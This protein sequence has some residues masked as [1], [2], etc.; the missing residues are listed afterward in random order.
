MHP[1]RKSSQSSGCVILWRRVQAVPAAGSAVGAQLHRDPVGSARI[2]A[3]RHSAGPGRD[4]HYTGCA[5]WSSRGSRRPT[6]TDAAISL[7]DPP[8]SQRSPDRHGRRSLGTPSADISGIGFRNILRFAAMQRFGSVLLARRT[9]PLLPARPG[10]IA[11]PRDADRPIRAR[12]FS[13]RSGG[14]S[15]R[16]ERPCTKRKFASPI[17]S[18]THVRIG[19]RWNQLHRC[20]PASRAAHCLTSGQSRCTRDR[21]GR[22]VLLSG[23]MIGQFQVRNQTAACSS[24]ASCQAEPTSFAA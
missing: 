6:R 12:L 22:P 24:P 19:Y 10:G 1:I 5:L 9:G 4:C 20:R 13:Q 15:L 17:R 14:D 21:Q 3:R 18:G 7:Q 16:L 23:T 2:A 8:S 11:I